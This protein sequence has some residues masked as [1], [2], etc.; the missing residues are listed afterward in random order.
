MIVAIFKYVEFLFL[1]NLSAFLGTYVISI[2][3][4]PLFST[5]VTII[6]NFVCTLLRYTFCAYLLYHGVLLQT[7]TVER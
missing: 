3:K 5:V 6:Q 1:L 7:V 4:I 2:F